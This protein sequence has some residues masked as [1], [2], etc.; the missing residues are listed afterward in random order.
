MSGLLQIGTSAVNAY[1]GALSTVSNN[2]ANI[3]TDGYSRQEVSLNSESP[4]V[5]GLL[6]F[7]SG[8]GIAGIRRAYDAFTTE[9]LRVSRSALNAQEPLLD[10]ANSVVDALGGAQSGLS[11]A[12]DDFFGAA[13]Q[14][15]ASPAS[16]DA[17]DSFLRSTDSLASRFRGLSGQLGRLEQETRGDV[18][19]AIESLNEIG[20]A[21]V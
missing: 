3:G 1:Q 11:S 2:I 10:Y 20:R 17:R 21:H 7:G 16:V 4:V 18:K 12:L 19:G 8:V 6:A 5:Q 14:L 9:N 13:N 15:S